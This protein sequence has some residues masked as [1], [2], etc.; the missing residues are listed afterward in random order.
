MIDYGD[1][2]QKEFWI[3]VNKV[4]NEDTSSGHARYVGPRGD[5][6]FHLFNVTDLWGILYV[7]LLK[8]YSSVTLEYQVDGTRS[9]YDRSYVKHIF[10]Y[11]KKVTRILKHIS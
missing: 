8:Q 10:S 6:E 3:I 11:S 2:K 1:E 9:N 4:F 7:T 5:R